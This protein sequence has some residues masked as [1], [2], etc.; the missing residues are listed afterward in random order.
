MMAAHK[1]RRSETTF[2]FNGIVLTPW[3]EIFLPDKAGRASIVGFYKF[4]WN[5]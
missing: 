1:T 4:R 3:V 5:L 2:L